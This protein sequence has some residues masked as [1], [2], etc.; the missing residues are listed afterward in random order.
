[1]TTALQSQNEA[2]TEGKHEVQTHARNSGN[3]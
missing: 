2:A 1:M 3:V